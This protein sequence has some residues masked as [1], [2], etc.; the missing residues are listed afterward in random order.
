VLE[1]AQFPSYFRA[2]LT[3]D[4]IAANDARQDPRTSEFTEAYLVPNG[5]ASMLDVPI[6]RDGEVAGVVC[7][8]HIGQ[9]ITWQPEQQV[10]ATAIAS[11]VSLLLE[12][13]D[14]MRIEQELR[15]SNA[16]LAAATRAKTDFLATMS[17]EIRTP[18]NGVLGMLGLL[19][20][21]RLSDEQR[22]FASTARN[23]AESLLAILNDI[24]DYSKLEAGKVVLETVSFS[25]EQVL[26]E[27]IS[28]C[29]PEARAKSLK[30][31]VDFAPEFPMW[32]AGDPVRLRQVLFNLI[33]NAIKFTETGSVRIGYQWRRGEGKTGTARFEVTDTGIGI[34]EASQPTLFTRFMQADPSTTRRFGGT[35][36]GLA[37]CK[38]LVELMGG[39][40]GVASLPG[41][42]STFWFE[43]P[44]ALGEPMLE[45]TQV[46]AGRLPVAPRTLK[47]LVADD[48]R[49]NQQIVELLLARQGHV[50]ACAANGR[51]AVAAVKR[52]SF[53]LVL[54]D[55]QMPEM[56]GPTATRLIRALAGP[57]ARIPVI[58]LTANAMPGQRE[59]YLAAGMTGY[60]AK[61]IRPLDLFTQIVRAVQAG[62]AADAAAA[63][64]APAAHDASAP[65]AAAQPP[66]AAAPTL[67]PVIDRDV[68]KSW[69]EGLAP[70]VIDGMLGQLEVE[71]GRCLNEIKAALVA[72][73][74]ARVQ[75][76]AH[77]LKGM[78]GNFGAARL[79]HVAASL[80][81]P[82]GSRGASAG[83]EDLELALAQTGAALK[84][85]A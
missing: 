44:F 20:D 65:P 22:R 55:V 70:A 24:L 58:A 25:A 46:D 68:I 60:V 18:M 41:K 29:E 76:I 32:L 13:R 3:E 73:E 84:Q 12:S 61:P 19:I 49:V 56:D 45:L 82:P 59:A 38:Q 8:E 35:G 71:S 74:M 67:P 83:L 5:I 63:A 33:A 31:S 54:M 16:E 11:L 2:M 77:R 37:I 47:V 28:L 78:A 39:N 10:F 50:V 64:P 23:S 75:A 30:L 79:A 42:G 62:P 34:P 48:N 9:P 85:S 80:E 14:R 4:Y 7:I 6:M 36:L 81:R 72:G 15:Q 52:E 53:D 27:V 57:A 40:I 66:S 21:T 1:A 51:E 17:H 43:V 26:D 69:S